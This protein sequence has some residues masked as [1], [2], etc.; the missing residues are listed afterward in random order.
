[1]R[2]ALGG[3][4]AVA[5][6]AVLRT[7]PAEGLFALAAGVGVVFWCWRDARARALALPALLLMAWVGFH[8]TAA[9][10]PMLD[11]AKACS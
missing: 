5:G 10:A 9:P 1:M 6:G 11:T 2:P 4:L 3:A 8:A 7:Y